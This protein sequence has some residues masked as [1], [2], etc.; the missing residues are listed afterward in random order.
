LNFLIKLLMGAFT[1]GFNVGQLLDKMPLSE[2]RQHI[3]VWF[4]KWFN[5]NF[6]DEKGK[7]NIIISSKLISTII[8]PS[9]FKYSCEEG[10]S[11]MESPIIIPKDSEIEN[12]IHSALAGHFHD[13]ADSSEVRDVIQEIKEYILSLFTSCREPN[14]D[15]ATDHDTETKDA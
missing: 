14:S 15:I 7:E 13:D 5:E 9:K 1:A 12:R 3:D 11:S 4:K 8:F 10:D 6:P 2:R